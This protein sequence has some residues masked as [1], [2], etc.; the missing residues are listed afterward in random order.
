[1]KQ[2][3]KQSRSLANMLNL[4]TGKP[5]QDNIV[6]TGTNGVSTWHTL[7]LR[8]GPVDNS[9]Y[10]FVIIL[11][12]ETPLKWLRMSVGTDRL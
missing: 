9:V 12:H 8:P 2:L 11:L 5:S 4:L 3:T 1:M 6:H 10:N 7:D